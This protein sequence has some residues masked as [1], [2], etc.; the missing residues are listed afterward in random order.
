M[1][2]ELETTRVLITV[3]T[4]PHPSEKYEELVCAA[5]ITDKGE[6]VRLYPLDYRYRPRKQQFQK[7][8]WIDVDLGPRGHKGDGRKESREPRLDSIRLVGEKLPTTKKW[9]ERR[10]IIDQM[11]HHTVNQ[12]R[13]L[14]EKEKISLGIVRPT[15]ILDLEIS[16]A[17]PEWKGKWKNIYKQLRLFGDPPK[18]LRKIPFEFRY[19]FECEDSAQPHKAMIT[20]WELGVLYLKE[21]AKLG[22]EEAAVESVKNKFFGDICRDD[23]DTR[24]FM[25]TVYPRN[26]WIVI[27]T[28]WPPKIK[29]QQT[30]LF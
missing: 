5:G 10:A 4:Y 14:Y 7:Y 22:S 12:L 2:T 20:D 24:F 26:T 25:G 29:E 9:A 30:Q 28:F 8:Q 6:W 27:G 18:P 16:K 15:R 17:D 11:P 1:T 19:V 13:S 21:E 3:K 23:K